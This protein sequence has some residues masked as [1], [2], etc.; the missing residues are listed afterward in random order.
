MTY[1]DWRKSS[2]VAYKQKKWPEMAPGIFNSREKT[3]EHILPAG[4]EKL[5]IIA[6]YR[7]EFYLSH[8]DIKFHPSFHHLNSSQ[9]LCF[10]L[11]FPLMHENKLDW[12]T[13]LLGLEHSQA[14]KGKINAVFEKNLN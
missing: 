4:D 5:N 12:L 14:S 10:N 2:L 9:A 1:A 11:F 6:P 8:S 3:Y 7:D 13:D